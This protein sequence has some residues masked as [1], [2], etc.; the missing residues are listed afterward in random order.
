MSSGEPK[1]RGITGITRETFNYK[2]RT[3][4]RRGASTLAT[5]IE[6]AGILIHGPR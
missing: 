2:N 4:D 5:S 1:R 3:A 6:V